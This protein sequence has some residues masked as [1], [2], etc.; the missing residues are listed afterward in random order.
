MAITVNTSSGRNARRGTR[1]RLAGA[2]FATASAQALAQSTVIEPGIEARF[3]A[4]TNANAGV[5]G[6][7]Q[8]RLEAIRDYFY[9]T[10]K[11]IGM[12]PAGG[13]R[14]AKQALHYL[15]MV[16]ETLGD[17]W[18]T[19]EMFRFGASVLLNDVLMQLEKEKTGAYQGQDYFSKD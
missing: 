10:G 15:V 4:T 17:A 16:K 11:R 9:A 5:T 1:L 14:T 19:N 12:K 7:A 2:L 8:S 3:V 6:A 18:L 13:I